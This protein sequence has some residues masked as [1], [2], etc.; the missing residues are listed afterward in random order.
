MV[1]NKSDYTQ[2]RK[3]HLCCVGL[4]WYLGLMAYQTS[5]IIYRQCHSSGTILPIPGNKVVHTFLQDICLM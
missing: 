1:Y 3:L 5:M 2:E 4:N